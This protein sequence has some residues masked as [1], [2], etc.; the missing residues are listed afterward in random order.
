MKKEFFVM[1][2]LAYSFIISGCLSSP[3]PS[4]AVTSNTSDQPP[5][6]FN[7]IA[8]DGQ[9]YMF[10]NKEGGL[11]PIIIAQYPGRPLL[12]SVYIVNR[13]DIEN[14][15]IDLTII[16]NPIFND[17]FSTARYGYL[18][19]RHINNDNWRISRNNAT[20]DEYVTMIK[21]PEGFWAEAYLDITV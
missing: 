8:E 17:Y 15:I 9:R 16:P 5:S 3:Y 19:I 6:Y 4:S 21:A 14:Y 11:E 2:I 1:L 18:T 20:V 7:S 13:T 12:W 10:K